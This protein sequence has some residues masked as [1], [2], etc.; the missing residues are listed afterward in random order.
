[1]AVGRHLPHDFLHACNMYAA[2]AWHSPAAAPASHSR[3]K[4]VVTIPSG[5]QCRAHGAGGAGRSVQFGQ[6]ALSSAHSARDDAKT[7]LLSRKSRSGTMSW[8]SIATSTCTVDGRRLWAPQV[9]S[10][11]QSGG[12]PRTCNQAH[13]STTAC[14][15][16]AAI[17]RGTPRALGRLLTSVSTPPRSH[18]VPSASRTPSP[19]PDTVL[20]LTHAARTLATSKRQAGTRLNTR[21][22][23]QWDD[24]MRR[25]HGQPLHA[26]SSNVRSV[27]S[28]R[29]GVAS[30]DAVD[31]FPAVLASREMRFRE[32]VVGG[33]ERSVGG[34]REALHHPRGRLA[35]LHAVSGAEDVAVGGG[36]LCGADADTHTH[37]DRHGRT[38]RSRA[39]GV[40]V[41]RRL[42]RAPGLR[43]QE[44]S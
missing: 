18:H 36:P 37:I 35:K 30:I 23:S 29:S 2:F 5:R 9:N 4:R 31:A 34:V 43:S 24:P 17:R 44:H 13:N 22:P 16:T 10:S 33:A 38:E 41:G 28:R 7:R 6:S 39:A 42:R 26:I 3:G 21:Q 32:A 25:P 40:R 1:M 11:R 19:N 8:S 15:W 27:R 20:R 14:V 12:R